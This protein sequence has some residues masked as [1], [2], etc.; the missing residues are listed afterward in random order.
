MWALSFVQS[1]AFGWGLPCTMLVPFGDCL[2]HSNDTFIGPELVEP[3]LHRAMDKVYLYKHNFDKA[4]K[5]HYSEDD[6]FDKSGSRKQINCA[7][8]FAEDLQS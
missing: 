2:N 5:K 4:N 1:R 8:L 7:K 6:L 3:N